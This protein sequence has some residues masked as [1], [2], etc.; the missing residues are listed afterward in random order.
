MFKPGDIVKFEDKE[1]HE[2]GEGTVN[3]VEYIETLEEGTFIRTYVLVPGSRNLICFLDEK[4]LTLVKDYDEPM[5]ESPEDALAF[6]N[7]EVKGSTEKVAHW[8]DRGLD[9]ALAKWLD[10]S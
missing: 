7:G 1:N 3:R 2:A 9:D 5:F 8:V 10:E 4:D 6:F